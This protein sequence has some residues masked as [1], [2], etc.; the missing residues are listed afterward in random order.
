M[1][2]KRA[3]STESVDSGKSD[4]IAPLLS[5]AP[6][7]PVSLLSAPSEKSVSSTGDNQQDQKV[8]ELSSISTVGSK[9]MNLE[10][11]KNSGLQSLKE[12]EKPVATGDVTPFDGDLS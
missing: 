3:V 8:S 1:G 9:V 7:S 11:L 10:E 4:N 6:S 5:A 12:V 2:K